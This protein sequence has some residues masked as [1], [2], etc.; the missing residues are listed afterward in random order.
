[1]EKPPAQ[2]IAATL[3]LSIAKLSETI[4]IAQRS[5]PSKEYESIKREV[6]LLIARISD[7]LLDPIY[8]K[9]PDLAPPGVL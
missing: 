5:L 8:E 6:G 1:V 3:E 2:E 7:K 9:F 4:V